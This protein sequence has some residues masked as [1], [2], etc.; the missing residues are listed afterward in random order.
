[1][2]HAPSLDAMALDTNTIPEVLDLPTAAQD[3]LAELA[4]EEEVMRDVD[5]DDNMS[6]NSN[7]HTT[8][9][10]S[11]LVD[12]H[13]Y[14]EKEEDERFL[15]PRRLPKGTS[16]YQ[17]A[18]ILDSDFEESDLE[19]EEDGDG[20]VDMRG[21]NLEEAAGP[22]DGQEGM[23]GESRSIYAPTELGDVQSEIFIDP[24]PEQEAEQYVPCDLLL[25]FTFLQYMQN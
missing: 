4:L 22:E 21:D 15:R 25:K 17:A 5:G 12:D 11:V 8:N 6:S 23:A 3:S 16:D 19:N 7:I 20:D 13:Y 10:S 18:W 24:S 2:E 1:M 14:F 9:P